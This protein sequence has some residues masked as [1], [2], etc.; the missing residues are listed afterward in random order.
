[1]AGNQQNELK[2]QLGLGMCLVL[3]VGGCLGVGIFAYTGSGIAFAGAGTPLAFVLAGIL[4]MI[5]YVPSMFL[6]SAIPATGGSYMYVSRFVHPIAGYLQILCSLIGALNIAVFAI[7]FAK[8]FQAV[9]PAADVKLVAL[10]V[11][12]LLAAVGT[13]GAKASTQIQ[14]IVV[15]CTVLALAVF[16]F[17]GFGAIKPEYVTFEKIF[18]GELGGLLAATALLRYTLQGGAIVLS[19]GDEVKDPNRTIPA[20]FF[21]GTAIVTVIY[22]VVSYVAVG[23]APVEE[24]ANQTLAVQ[25]AI[26]LKG[27]LFTFFIVAGGLLATL[28]SINT[29][30]LNYSRMHWVAARDGIWPGVF[31][32]LNKKQVPYVTLWTIVCVAAIIIILDISVT[33]VL[34]LVTLPSMILAF[35]FY[36]PPILVTKKLPHCAKNARF[37]LPQGVIIGFCVFSVAVQLYLSTSILQRLNIG[38]I[39]GLLGFFSVGLAYWFIRVAYNK[40]NGL[41]L[42]ANMKGFHPFWIETEEKYCMAAEEAEAAK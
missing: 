38:A 40:K 25:A 10:G 1:M 41:D 31:K 20:A 42:V 28:L 3:S 7:T 4:T 35:L 36:L 14:N 6:G 19:L 39:L 34:S 22:A 2:R 37:R 18:T 33:V 29:G 26:F 16:V 5:L 11:L 17:F 27:P 21:L 13:F 9:V 12:I 30:L 23:V 15:I 24:T 32:K 8:Y